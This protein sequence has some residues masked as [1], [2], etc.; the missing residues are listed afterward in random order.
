[1]PW[2]VA[3]AL[4]ADGWYLRSAAPWVKR[5]AMP[6]SV[7]DRPSSAV[8]Y[9]FLFA[10]AEAYFYDIDATRIAHRMTPQRRPQ[11]RAIDDTP[12][13]HGQPKQAWPTAARED[14][15]VDG[16]PLGRN[17]RNSDWWFAS[18][19]MLISADEEMLGFD[20]APQPYA[21]RHFAT[22]P[23]ALVEPMIL[24]GT[25]AYGACSAPVK[26]LRLRKDLTPFEEVNVPCGAPW[27]RVIARGASSWEARKAAGH[28]LRY[29]HDGGG[30]HQGRGSI[31]TDRPLEGGLGFVATRETTGW[32]PTCAHH[33]PV[34]PC[35]ILD[36]F[37]GAGTVGLVADRLGRDALL[38]ELNPAYTALATARL[39]DDAPLFWQEETA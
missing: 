14:L 15:G 16:H 33:A 9:V 27:E 37:A 2:R 30:Q 1:L 32:R 10:K 18:V 8:E 12:R 34:I 7:R 26:K 31:T 6:E 24:A 20:V 13:P 35:T 4:Q 36:P 19:G 21:E 3:F 25:S 17:R 29:G 23:P 28:P 38:L 5:S 39:R 11:G 22:F